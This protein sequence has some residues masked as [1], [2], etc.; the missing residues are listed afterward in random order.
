MG[1]ADLI[2][3][4][5]REGD[6]NGGEQRCNDGCFLGAVVA[7]LIL[8]AGQHDAER[9]VA[10]PG[11]DAVHR[12]T[13]GYFEYGAHELGQQRA[14]ILEQ[15]EVEQQREQIAGNQEDNDEPDDQVICQRTL[16]SAYDRLNDG[17][18]CRHGRIPGRGEALAEQVGQPH[19]DA[20]D[21]SHDDPH[22]R[23]GKAVLEDLVVHD[24]PGLGQRDQR[25]HSGDRQDHEA[26]QRQIAVPD[27]VLDPVSN[28]LDD[29]CPVAVRLES[30]SDRDHKD[31]HTDQRRDEEH[32]L[33]FA[34]VLH[35]I[36][37]F[38]FR[39]SEPCTHLFYNIALCNLSIRAVILV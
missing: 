32:R 5:Q 39:L 29:D 25:H 2:E 18:A 4:D 16:V 13:A 15:A 24:E 11:G 34:F 14:D 21:H 7:A 23:A 12:G 6:R 37:S 10:D 8:V 27:Q 30:A 22:R 9:T 19:A 28:H 31:Q 17:I 26:E 33:Q 3:N 36:L 1:Q 38:H 20:A 35:T